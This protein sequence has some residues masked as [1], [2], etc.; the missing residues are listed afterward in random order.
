MSGTSLFL[1]TF[2]LLIIPHMMTHWWLFGFVMNGVAGTVT[3]VLSY[4]ALCSVW[5]LV[6]AG[7]AVNVGRGFLREKRPPPLPESTEEHL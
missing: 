4:L 7:I 3:D 2:L 6:V 1:L 5:I